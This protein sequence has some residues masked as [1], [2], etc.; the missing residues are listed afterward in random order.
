[1]LTCT[2]GTRRC[3]GR[4][5]ALR[6]ATGRRDRPPGVPA[7]RRRPVG[8]TGF[9]PL[10]AQYAVPRDELP[11]AAQRYDDASTPYTP[12]QEP[13][14]SKAG[15]VRARAA[16]SCPS[17]RLRGPR[18]MIAMGASLVPLPDLPQLLHPAPA[19]RPVSTAAGRTTHARRRCARSPVSRTR[20]RADWQRPTRHMTGTVLLP[21]QRPVALREL[22]GPASWPAPGS[23]TFSNHLRRL[24]SPGRPARLTS[25]HP[26]PTRPAGHCRRGGRRRKPVAEYAWRSCGPG[27][28]S[29]TQTLNR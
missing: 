15:R 6:S 27:C 21:A 18:S 19:V 5:G 24:P 22:P 16:A 8:T 9:R 4:P 26:A 25:S 14:T 12:A 2:G 11:G 10:M 3:P 28:G 7:V 29:P 1:M 13:I 17:P 23:G 20:L